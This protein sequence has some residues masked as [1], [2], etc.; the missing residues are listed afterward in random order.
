MKKVK[1]PIHKMGK[2]T[3]YNEHRDGAIEV[4]PIYSK[5][6]ED[7]LVDEEAITNLLKKIVEHC[8]NLQRKVAE[9]RRR[10]WDDLADDY[11]LDRNKPY[12]YNTTSKLITF[13]KTKA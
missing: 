2:R 5:R 9:S 4:A 13:I 12:N 3:G 11:G 8:N 1:Y 6:F 7:L 10:L